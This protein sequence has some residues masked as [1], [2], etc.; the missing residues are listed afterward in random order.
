[1]KGAGTGTAEVTWEDRKRNSYKSRDI[2]RC[3]HRSLSVEKHTKEPGRC[4]DSPMKGET[5]WGRLQHELR[6]KI[7]DACG[8]E[9]KPL[10]PMGKRIEKPPKG[11]TVWIR[12]KG[13]KN[14][15]EQRIPLI[16]KVGGR[17]KGHR[18]L[19]GTITVNRTEE[20]RL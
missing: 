8:T 15:V 9:R 2:I 17:E 20:K 11:G 12:K 6:S 16:G 18:P 1:V 14:S 5:I 4:H 3:R 10:S 7:N 13:K 19:R